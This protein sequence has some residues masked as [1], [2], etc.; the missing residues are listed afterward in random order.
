MI[1]GSVFFMA[2]RPENLPRDPALLMEL[3]IALDAE[4]ETLRATIASLKGLIF[5]ARSERMAAILAEQLALDLQDLAD[6]VTPSPA[7]DDAPSST[8]TGSRNSR[9]KQKR[10]IGALP[11]DLPRC[12]QIIGPETTVCP[13][14]AG[15]LH[16]I[17]E[18]VSEALDV[19]PAIL[20][21][22]RTIRPK[23]ACRACEEVVVQAKAPARLIEGGMVTT[24]LV[25]H[26]AV[27]KYGWQSTLYRQMQILAGYGV[28]LD[29]S[30]LARWV[31]Q[32]AWMLKAL[33]LL[34]LAHMHGYPRLFCD[35][36][37]MP[38]IDPGRKRTKICQFWTHATD[39]RSW[40]GPAPPAVAYVF[41]EGRS[42]KE[43][44]AQLAKFS[45][46]LQVDGYAAYKSLESDKRTAGKIRL[47]FCLTH[48]RRKFV[49]V[50]KA[51]NSPFAQEVIERIAEVYAIEK[52]IRGTSA[53]NRRAVRQAETKPI[54]EALHARFVAVSDG[55]SK[56]STL[57]EAI[58]Y[59]LGHWAGLTLFLD[60][61]RLEPDTN[62]V[63]G[64]RRNSSRR[65]CG[66]SGEGKRSPPWPRRWVFRIRRCITG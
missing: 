42:K 44:A 61:G 36:T 40:Q 66:L 19:V 13:C 21:V 23:Y 25:A 17:G 62:S 7:N 33:Y 6:D 28:H 45:G 5:G 49:A 38:V 18:D 46:V 51:T 1:R 24:A 20:R 47:A 57:R 22:L 10:N 32:A 55:L 39:D 43:I 11:K 8:Q 15:K 65:R 29:R 4:N 63:D 26:I 14:C 34:Q 58:D 27:A 2:L 35:E 60:D 12:E 54:M 59:T 56:I 53:E 37:P 41:A 30:T 64:T 31:K 52:R 9:S 50:H 48:A 16:R 3:A